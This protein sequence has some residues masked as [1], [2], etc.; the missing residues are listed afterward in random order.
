MPWWSQRVTLT[1][2]PLGV[3]LDEISQMSMS[4]GGRGGVEML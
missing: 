2:W 1:R 4:G 3:D